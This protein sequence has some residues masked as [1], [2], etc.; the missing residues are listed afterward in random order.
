MLDFEDE[1]D[2]ATKPN[3][4]VAPVLKK[5]QETAILKLATSL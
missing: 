5:G 3:S 1:A 4:L 2:F